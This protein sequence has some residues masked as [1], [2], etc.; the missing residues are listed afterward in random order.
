MYNF[1]FSIA[2]GTDFTHYDIDHEHACFVCEDFVKVLDYRDLNCDQFQ[3][4]GCYYFQV[5]VDCL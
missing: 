2:N 4:A 1:V 5:L 3:V